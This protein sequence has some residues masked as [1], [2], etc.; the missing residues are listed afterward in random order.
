MKEIQMNTVFV[1]EVIICTKSRRG[2]GKDKTS[3]IRVITEVFDTSG[4]KI[5]EYDPCKEE[6]VFVPFDLVSFAR[7]ILEKGYV[8]VSHEDVIKWKQITEIA[9]EVAELRAENK[10]L[11]S[12]NDSLIQALHKPVVGGPASASAK[13]GEQLGNGGSAKSVCDGCE[14]IAGFYLGT[15]CPKCNRPFRQVK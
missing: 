9:I 13:E 5:A 10:L 8:K 14:D 12:F 11:K 6:E 4:E 15:T 2:T 3:P 1:S 7:W